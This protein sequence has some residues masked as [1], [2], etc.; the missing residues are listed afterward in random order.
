MFFVFMPKITGELCATCLSRI[1]ELGY[2]LSASVVASKFK[3]RIPCRAEMQ[4]MVFCFL[5]LGGKHLVL[6]VTLFF[7]FPNPGFLTPL[8]TLNKA[9]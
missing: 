7:F 1:S 3:E 5:F 9:L 2:L 4:A 6:K 8:P